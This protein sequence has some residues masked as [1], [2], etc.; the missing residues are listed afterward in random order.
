MINISKIFCF[1]STLLVIIL[2]LCSSEGVFSQ[3]ENYTF[4]H[5]TIEDGLTQSTIF[6]I[7]QDKIGFMWFGTTDGLNKYDGYK[8]TPYF[9]NSLDSNSI[10]GNSIREIYEDGAGNIWIGTVEGELNKFDRKTE[11][12]AHYNL[13][14]D[15]VV[16][17]NPSYRYYDYPLA[18]SRNIDGT[19]TAIVEENNEYLWIGTWGKGLYLFNKNDRSTT[20]F[21][22]DPDDSTSIPS[23]RITKLA[24]DSLN[25][26]WIGTFG[27][28]LS[29]MKQFDKSEPAKF[30]NYKHLID[31]TYSLSDD[32][33]ISLLV[34][35]KNSL[36]VGTFH[37][38]LNILDSAQFALTPPEV[39]F[40]IYH[41]VGRDDKGL[42]TNSVMAIKEDESHNKWIGTFGGGL[43]KFRYPDNSITTF[44][45]NPFDENTIADNDILSLLVDN[46]GVVWIGTHLGKGLSKLERNSVKFSMLQRQRGNSN[47]LN[48]DVVWAVYEDTTNVLWIGTYRGGLNKY[49]RR[50]G[51]FT[52]YTSSDDINS[53]SDDHVRAIKEDNS[54]N[55]WIGTYGGGLNHFDKTT[56]IFTRYTHDLNDPST[57]G[58]NQ[59]QA[60][61]I[62][63]ENICWVGTFGGG[64][65]KFDINSIKPGDPIEFKKYLYNE[66]ETNSISDNRIYSLYEDRKKN[67]WIGTYG[68]GLNK[69]NRDTDNFE[70]F[71][72]DFYDRASISHDQILSIIEGSD[73][74]IWVGTN[75][76]GLNKFDV[77][78]LRFEKYSKTDG[79]TSQVI[80]GILEDNKNN[81]WMSS[82]IGLSK[83]NLDTENITYYNLN[84]GLQSM[85]FSGGAYFKNNKGELFFGGINGLNYLFPDSVRGNTYVPPVVISEFKIF[86]DVIKGVQE[87]I[88]LSYDQNFFTIEY[89]ALDYTDPGNNQYAHILEGLE[90]Q[91]HPTDAIIRRAYYTNLEPGK[92]YF[93]VRGSNN[94]GVWNNVGLTLEID[95]LP[96]F[97][98][99]WWFILLNIILLGGLVSFLISMKVRHLLAIEKLKVRLAADLHDN[100][101]AGLTEIA[102]LSELTSSEVKG[103]S[104]SSADK[105]DNIS[106]TA[107]HLV[108]SMSDIVW[109]VNPNRDSL[110]DLIIRLKDSYSDLLSEIG[111]SFGTNN[112][113]NI[114][115]IKI[116]MDVRQNLYLIFKEAINNSIKHSECNKIN[117]ETKL[118]GGILEITLQDNGKG[119]D[120][121]TVKYGN[122]LRNMKDR[123][124]TLR[125]KLHIKSID[126]KGTTIR[127]VGRLER[128][129]TFK[130]KWK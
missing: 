90:D 24:K 5:L 63:S 20:H 64:L 41:F 9:N 60:I 112:I 58:S 92:Y 72:Y 7:L 11:S 95:I 108:D 83:Y 104:Q 3:T 61:L 45:N 55:L 10:S 14:A 34:D 6:C 123:A 15:S 4:K 1:K 68:G 51:A 49:D 79:I 84:D 85:E 130:F 17:Y 125:G 13:T 73:N 57:I 29:R 71:R 114:V 44:T 93:R 19:I 31:S 46:S 52:Y 2:F 33:I 88:E 128:Q 70:I 75:G 94:D 121:S 122:G 69:Y 38:G 86:N 118:S 115:D 77:A 47:S 30:F 101:G 21:Y 48:D 102:I 124:E 117:L 96:P 54:G 120:E 37:G 113:D 59:I 97:W 26:L 91:W 81:L 53:I 119:I 111:I 116:P 109:F 76:G 65:H 103:F 89:A 107:R 40:R 99:T 62:D 82:D 106:D 87:S 27:G 12:F 25:N 35:H 18:F 98:K 100:V 39:E 43:H 74:N 32:K 80:Y 105:L 129:S 28:G 67:V 16:V 126:T 42:S 36:W 50:T 22:N 66:T 78:N 110:H 127:F 23:N 56:G 8:F